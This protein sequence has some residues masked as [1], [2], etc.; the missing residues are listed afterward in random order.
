M[1]LNTSTC[2]HLTPLRFKWLSK[3]CDVS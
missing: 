1:A 2:N 3:P